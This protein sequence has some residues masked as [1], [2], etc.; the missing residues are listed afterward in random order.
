VEKEREIKGL[1]NV[2]RRIAGDERH[3]AWMNAQTDA[4]RFNAVRYNKVLARISEIEPSVAQL[5]TPLPEDSS[6]EVIHMAAR[7]L[8]AFFEE[9]APSHS[10]RR[11]R[12]G[13]CRTGRVVIGWTPTQGRCW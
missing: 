10:W 8:S 1:V 4:T 6:H 7:E 9:E 3:A 11:Q 5:F 13:R 12:H 2:L